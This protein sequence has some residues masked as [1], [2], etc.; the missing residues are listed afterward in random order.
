MKEILLKG[1]EVHQ[2]LA[3]GMGESAWHVRAWGVS[4][5]SALVAYSFTSSKPEVAIVAIVLLF[6][7]FIVEL[8]IR[9]I[10]YQYIAK[11][12]AIEASI[13]SI[14][15][16]DDP[17]LP[18]GGISTNILTPEISTL[19]ELLTLK[20]WLIWLPYLLLLFCSIFA[21]ACA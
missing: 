17:S 1:W 9:Q 5:W 18:E 6:S 21:L 11:S 10:Q 12:V 7:V 2:S 16:G 8:A 3:K 13:N 15:V 4:V 19:L 20:R 14:L